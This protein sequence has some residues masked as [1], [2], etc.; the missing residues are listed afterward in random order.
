MTVLVTGSAGHL[1][2]A[3]MRLLRGRGDDARGLD[4]KPSPFTDAVGSIGDSGFVREAMRG[5]RA[6]LHTATLHKPHIVT[7]SRQDFVDTNVTGTV[8]L[9]EEAARAGVGAFVQTSTT[10]TF[11]DAMAHE[12]GQPA[13]WI[14][15][16]VT[17]VPKNIYGAT[18][19]AAEHSCREIA[20]NEGLPVVILR[21]SRFFPE[22]DD[23]AAARAG[24]AQ[25]NLQAL[26]LLYRRADIADMASAHLLA[27]ERAGEAGVGPFIVSA[28]T[29]FTEA[30]LAGLGRDAGAIVRA[31][32]P[33]SEPLFAEQ[34]WHF[35]TAI[36]RVYSNRRACEALGWRP[37]YDFRHVLDCL[38]KGRDFRSDLAL[39]VGAKGYHDQ[40]FVDGPYPV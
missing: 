18:K 16:D 36:D 29:P 24:F 14:D 11:G 5:A 26:E 17:P 15:E 22:E 27:I 9:L 28:T 30:D 37:R 38:A 13:T 31:R 34:G 4:R 35:F 23:S 3:L 20:R 21:T 33:E 39:A 32:Y 6:V 40:A 12:P 25:D 2:E 10:S 1:G 7:H 8:V 19:L